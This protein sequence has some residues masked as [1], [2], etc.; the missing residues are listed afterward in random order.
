MKQIW[1]TLGASLRLQRGRL[2]LA[3]IAMAGRA[4]VLVFTP[5]PLKYIVNVII[6]G[7]TAPHWLDQ[8]ATDRWT[9]LYLF[10]A[11]M[12]AFAMADALLDYLGNHLVLQ[13]GQRMVAALRRDVFAHLLV[14][15]LSWHRRRRG[16]DVMTRLSEDVGRVQDLVV[17]VG[18]GLLPHVLTV[19]GIL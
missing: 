15:P 5:W 7:K 16:G 6:L 12:L 11:A 9:L 18:T 17:V 1:A 10:G 14:L 4:V 19:L 8:V 13:A 3:A 2:S